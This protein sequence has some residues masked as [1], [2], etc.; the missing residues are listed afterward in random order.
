MENVIP[1]KHSLDNDANLLTYPVVLLT[2]DL[3][4]NTPTR[5]IPNPIRVSVDGSGMGV[6]PSTTS[7]ASVMS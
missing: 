1:F 4:E 5:S 6:I 3:I 7:Y 2:R